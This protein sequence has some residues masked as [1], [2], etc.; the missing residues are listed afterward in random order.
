M[1]NSTWKIIVKRHQV[2]LSNEMFQIYFFLSSDSFMFVMAFITSWTHFHIFRHLL[3]SDQNG[4]LF[5]QA[6]ANHFSHK[7]II[8]LLTHSSL[9][10]EMVNL[11]G[12]LSH[13]LTVCGPCNFFFPLVALILKLGNFMQCL[14]FWLFLKNQQL[15]QYCT[16]IPAR[17][18]CVQ[19]NRLPPLKRT[20]APQVCLVAASL[21]SDSC[22]APGT[23]LIMANLFFSCFLTLTFAILQM[24][25]RT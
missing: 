21:P 12:Y 23:V 24:E 2:N 19:L 20:W 10:L 8:S 5:I 4:I 9:R 22:V 1:I 17:S 13:R 3:D 25:S 7:Q 6:Q 14:N 11:G 18:L 16:H 15:Q